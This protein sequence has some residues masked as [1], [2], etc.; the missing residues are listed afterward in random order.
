MGSSVNQ[1]AMTTAASV[2]EDHFQHIVDL[3]EFTGDPAVEL[4]VM[5]ADQIPPLSSHHAVYYDYYAL[6]TQHRPFSIKRMVFAAIYQRVPSEPVM[7]GQHVQAGITAHVLQR[8]DVDTNRRLWRRG[9]LRIEAAVFYVCV[10][11]YVFA[12][13]LLEIGHLDLLLGVPD[14]R[15][16]VGPASPMARRH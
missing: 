12:P 13:M 3:P 15:V 8:L 2:E 14:R 1:P 7:N 4:P 11:D 16:H 9:L 6:E 10:R 5:G